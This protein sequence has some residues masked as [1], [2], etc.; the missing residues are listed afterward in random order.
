MH[1]LP[2]LIDAN[3]NRSQEAL[4]VCEDLVRFILD[5]RKLSASFKALRH[6]LGALAGKEFHLRSRNVKKDV[7]K[8]TT[9]TEGKRKDLA[10]VFRANI[11]RAKESLRVLEEVSKLSDRKIAESFKKIRFKAYELEKKSRV[12][13]EGLLHNR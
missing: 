2:R 5:D 13:L 1:R 10:G 11:Q 7:G 9:H 12:K 3:L 8:K 6:K 4:R